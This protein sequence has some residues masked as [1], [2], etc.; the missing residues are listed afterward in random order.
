MRRTSLLVALLV[1]TTLKAA[2]QD[3][4]TLAA[5]T[6]VT[7]GQAVVTRSPDR[8]F[9]SIAVET[10]AATS[11]QAQQQNAEAMASVQHFSMPLSNRRNGRGPKRFFSRFEARIVRLGSCMNRADSPKSAGVDGIIDFQWKM[12]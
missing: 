5:A 4:G 1:F 10:R 9:V 11:R 8:A 6:V 7:T 12:P 3:T 2:A